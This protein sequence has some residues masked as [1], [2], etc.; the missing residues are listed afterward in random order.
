MSVTSLLCIPCNAQPLKPGAQPLQPIRLTLTGMGADLL[1]SRKVRVQPL[2]ERAH[3]EPSV[4]L[5]AQR[6][7]D[8]RVQAVVVRLLGD[9]FGQLRQDVVAAPVRLQVAAGR[10]NVIRGQHQFD[11]EGLIGQHARGDRVYRVPIRVRRELDAAPIVANDVDQMMRSQLY[12]LSS[13]NT[14]RTAPRAPARAAR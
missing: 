11:R 12:R 3:G 7:K 5:E 9:R 2:Q 10:A 4:G 8:A 14:A 1:D 13:I 6:R